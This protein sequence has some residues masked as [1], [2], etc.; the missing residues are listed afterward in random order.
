MFEELAIGRHGRIVV[1]TGG[2]GVGRGGKSRGFFKGQ[3]HLLWMF[4]L[5]LVSVIRRHIVNGLVRR[6]NGGGVG[7]GD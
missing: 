7:G 3:L 5:P 2:G 6:R 4:I 1:A